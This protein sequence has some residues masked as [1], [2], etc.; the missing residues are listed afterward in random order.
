M[1]RATVA[2][3]LEDAETPGVVDAGEAAVLNELIGA[4]GT[5]DEYEAAALRQIHATATSVH[6]SLMSV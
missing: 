1:T 4:D 3:A 5:T 2:Y 6:P